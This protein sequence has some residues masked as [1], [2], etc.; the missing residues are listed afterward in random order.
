MMILPDVKAEERCCLERYGNVYREYMN[1]T[2]RWIGIPKSGANEY[3]PRDFKTILNKYRFID[4]WF[5]YRY[6]INPY[7]RN[8]TPAMEKLLSDFLNER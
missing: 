2:P 4:S 5:W 8:V 7:I 6:S 3:I 1:R